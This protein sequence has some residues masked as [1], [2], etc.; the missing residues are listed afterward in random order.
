MYFIRKITK[1]KKPA[2]MNGNHIPMWFHLAL[3]MKVDG[4]I[5]QQEFV[6]ALQYLDKN[7]IIK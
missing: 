2:G 7:E 5:S 1:T 3:F 6:N 4:T